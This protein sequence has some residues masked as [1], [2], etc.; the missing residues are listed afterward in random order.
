MK[1]RRRQI[2]SAFFLSRGLWRLALYRTYQASALYA[3]A[4]ET[5]P[6]SLGAVLIMFV[7]P[8]AAAARSTPSR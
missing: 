3:G 6:A 5:G 7:R 1:T 2:A 4:S 8:P